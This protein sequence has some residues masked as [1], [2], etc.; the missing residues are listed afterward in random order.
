M[1]KAT[2]YKVLIVDDDSDIRAVIAEYLADKGYE[3][4]EAEDGQDGLVK[5]D[6]A[7]PDIV[8][9]DMKMP[10]ISG[11]KLISRLHHIAPD[12]PIIAITGHHTESELYAIQRLGAT[13]GLIKPFSLRELA[14]MIQSLLQHDEATQ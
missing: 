3:V 5:F 7:R 2:P 13:A 14:E 12:M 1:I 9:T 11:Q 4:A 6:L 10:K 8:V